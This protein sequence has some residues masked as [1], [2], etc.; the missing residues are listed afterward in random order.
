MLPSAASRA[1]V[2]FPS[3][4]I[5]PSAMSAAAAPPDEENI[6]GVGADETFFSSI[7]ALVASPPPSSSHGASPDLG[8][9]SSGAARAAND[10]LSANAGL[11]F[12]SSRA[13]GGAVPPL[14][15]PPPTAS[16]HGLGPPRPLLPPGG[17]TGGAGA[18]APVGMPATG[19]PSPSVPAAPR[20][21]KNTGSSKSRAKGGGIRQKRSKSNASTAAA[22][23][24]AG[25]E[26][27][28]PDKMVCLLAVGSKAPQLVRAGAGTSSGDG[29]GNN[30]SCTGAASL[31]ETVKM[32]T[33]EM[34]RNGRE[35]ETEHVDTGQ[36]AVL[37]VK[38]L[39][40][41][42]MRFGMVVLEVE[43]SLVAAAEIAGELRF[44]TV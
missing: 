18:M 34:G 3:P 28:E 37:Q 33:V 31:D 21:K 10:N 17:S 2:I 27:G 13:A 26:D 42:D 38:A 30:D 40:R 20:A 36:R 12:D 15:A 8:W 14:L 9:P 6:F 16:G 39:A 29:G 11:A 4:G 5:S 23:R 22:R 1:S 43:E 19:T 7:E 41:C 35:L 32:L 24:E 44:V 25:L